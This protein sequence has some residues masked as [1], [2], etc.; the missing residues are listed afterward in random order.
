MDEHISEMLGLVADLRAMG[1]EMKEALIVAMILGSLPEEYD[2][3]VT[4]LEVRPKE[5]L[6]IMT[7]KERLIQAY[8]GIS[9]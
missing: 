9:S 6:T 5:E 3:L 1:E 8:S 7:I 2:S 4:A